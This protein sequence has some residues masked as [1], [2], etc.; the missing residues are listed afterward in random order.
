MREEHEEARFAEA[1]AR[2]TGT[3]LA[4]GKLMAIVFP[5]VM[6]VFNL[7]TVAVIWFGAHRVEAGATQMGQVIAFM[8]Y[9]MQILMSVMMAVM[10]TMMIPRA[11]VSAGRITEVLD[12]STSVRQPERPEPIRVLEGTADQSGPGGVGGRV[13]ARLLPLP[14]C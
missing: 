5:A 8:S 9:M 1:N 6:L 2:Y 12:T 10:M 7:S 4:V 13:R 11:S 14:R 3:S